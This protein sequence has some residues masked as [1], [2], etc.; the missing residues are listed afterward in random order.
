MYIIINAKNYQ[1][2]F[3]LFFP[4]KKKYAI[5]VERVLKKAR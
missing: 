3:Y 5:K 2:V 4:L 1:S